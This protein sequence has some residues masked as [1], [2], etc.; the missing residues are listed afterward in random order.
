MNY[1]VNSSGHL[2]RQGQGER[3]LVVNQRYQQG[4]HGLQKQSCNDLLGHNFSFITIG[5]IF[6][7]RTI[8][9]RIFFPFASHSAEKEHFKR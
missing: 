5:N 7:S 2:V 8:R 9:Y 6:F 4:A 1:L 3:S